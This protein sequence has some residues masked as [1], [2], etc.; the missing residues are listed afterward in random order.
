MCSEASWSGVFFLAAA[1][2]NHLARL[3]RPPLVLHGST[4]G[5][6]CR[7]GWHQEL[8]D[9][10]RFV[11][12]VV[13][14]LVTKKLGEGYRRPPV[15]ARPCPAVGVCTLLQC[16]PR[17]HRNRFRWAPRDPSHRHP[18]RF[19]ARRPT[20]WHLE[21][22]VVQEQDDG[23]ASRQGAGS[24]IA[25][26]RQSGVGASRPRGRPQ[27]IWEVGGLHWRGVVAD[28]TMCWGSGREVSRR[29]RW[30]WKWGWPPQCPILSGRGRR[31]DPHGRR[32]HA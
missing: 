14:L 30:R 16:S 23:K 5:A 15:A 27:Q 31:R 11:R 18:R 32:E 13:F 4:H 6:A 9:A 25:A 20:P 22:T 12:H 1:A 3:S 21:T 24:A 26:A 17:P 10:A 19:F 8:T 28:D 2:P 29:R 7:A